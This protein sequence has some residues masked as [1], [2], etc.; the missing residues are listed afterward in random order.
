[1]S[2]NLII[3][4]LTFLVTSVTLYVLGKKKKKGQTIAR[5]PRMAHHLVFVNKI[6]LE[7]SHSHLLMYYL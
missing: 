3:R 7:H 1:M 4:N 2:V 6:V 5:G